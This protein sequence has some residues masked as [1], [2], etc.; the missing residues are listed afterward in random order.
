MRIIKFRVWCETLCIMLTQEKDNEIKNLWDIPKARG[1]VIKYPNGVL[2]QFTDLKDKNGK[3]IY[4]GD[5]AL[6]SKRVKG[7]Q[8]VKI[9]WC[10]WMACYLIKGI[11]WS[12]TLYSNIENLEI[13]GNIHENPELIG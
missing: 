1:G 5:I 10:D 8:S 13:I 9:I 11:N 12:E 3:E 6:D 4:E 7:A 2:M